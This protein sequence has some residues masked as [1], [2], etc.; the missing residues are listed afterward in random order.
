MTKAS[1]NAFPSLLLNETTAPA[2]PAASKRRFYVDAN[3]VLRSVD[4]ASLDS[5]M[6][7]LNK[8]NATTAPTVNEDSGDGYAV[9]SVWIDTT[10]GKAYTCLDAT[11][12]AAVWALYTGGLTN[13]MN[14][15]E[16]II[17]GG[18]S[19]TPTRKAI[20]NPGGALSR[21]NGALAYNS[22]TA[23]PTAATGDRFWRTDL[24][25][26]AFYDGT[27]WLS[28]KL[29]NTPIECT[30]GALPYTVTTTGWRTTAPFSAQYD[31]WLEDIEGWIFIS[32]GTALSASHKWVFTL[33]KQP[34][35]S[36]I[37][38]IT[39]DS[40]SLNA[41]RGLGQTSI[42]ALLGTTNFELDVTATKT[43]T[44]G[45]LFAGFRF[46]SRIVLT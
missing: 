22:G 29:Y 33:A 12:G 44:P 21:I 24:R 39:V 32:G 26:G 5:P 19:G 28:D 2:A 31:L 23:F 37:A 17:Y 18:A 34:A 25:L 6:V 38:T 16:D 36:T 1:D 30:A 8:W 10:N 27:R 3:H 14:A 40:G 46:R 41:Y 45:S 4:S 43:G 7:A 35:G 11:V 15:A 42:G 9:G 13:P 20:G